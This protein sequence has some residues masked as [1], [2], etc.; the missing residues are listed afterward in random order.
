VAGK[1]DSGATVD[2]RESEMRESEASQPTVRLTAFAATCIGQGGEPPQ[3][4]FEDH[5]SNSWLDTG[6]WEFRE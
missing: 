6:H 5:L 4:L 3:C 1:A 2:I